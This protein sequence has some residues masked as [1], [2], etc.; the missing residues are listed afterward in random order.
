MLEKDGTFPFLLV[1]LRA[2][3]SFR[4]RRTC[5]SFLVSLLDLAISS[6]RINSFID[7]TA[8]FDLRDICNFFVH[9]HI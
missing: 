2:A 4:L 9:S 6:S 8:D 7:F 5:V 1:L 3:E